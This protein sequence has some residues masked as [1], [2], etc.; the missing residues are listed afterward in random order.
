MITIALR[1]PGWVAVFV[2]AVMVV[3]P[4]TL[5][6][7]MGRESAGEIP[8]TPARPDGCVMF[9]ATSITAQGVQ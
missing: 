9:C 8:R 2:L 3:L 6:L 1:R 4:V 5:L 7:T